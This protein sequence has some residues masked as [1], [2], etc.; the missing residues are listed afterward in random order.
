[1]YILRRIIYIVVFARHNHDNHELSDRECL[2]KVVTCLDVC[3][4]SQSNLYD[5]PLRQIADL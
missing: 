2:Y 3:M 1:M 4:C 5:H